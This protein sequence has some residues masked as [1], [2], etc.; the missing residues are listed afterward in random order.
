MSTQAQKALNAETNATQPE[1]TCVTADTRSGTML[2]ISRGMSR[3]ATNGLAA[4]LLTSLFSHYG[5]RRD[6]AILAYPADSRS[7]LIL[8][9]AR[10]GK[11]IF[12]NINNPVGH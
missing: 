3:M 12:L 5:Q 1:E 7:L 2:M 11:I 6:F 8:P 10:F 9:R 4:F